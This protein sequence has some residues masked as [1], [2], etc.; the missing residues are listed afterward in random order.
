MDEP[1]SA[2]FTAEQS[3]GGRFIFWPE[4]KMKAGRANNRTTLNA[5]FHDRFYAFA[6]CSRLSVARNTRIA[7]FRQHAARRTGQYQPFIPR[8]RLSRL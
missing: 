6:I 5:N 4:R 1:G 8:R 2:F 7:A 3:D